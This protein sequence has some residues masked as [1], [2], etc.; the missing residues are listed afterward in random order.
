[1][2]HITPATAQ[3]HH[4]RNFLAGIALALP[5]SLLLAGL[6]KLVL[7]ASGL[8]NEN[9][10]W[11]ELALFAALLFLPCLW[12]GMQ[13][14]PRLIARYDGEALQAEP[15]PTVGHYA[16]GAQ[17]AIQPPVWTAL[18]AWCRYGTGTG[19][20]PF[21]R[22]SIPPEMA[23]PFSLAVMSGDDAAGKAR[24]AHAFARHLDRNDELAALSATS[25]W[26]GVLLKLAV[27]WHELWWWR[28]RHPRQPWDCGYLADD[29][30]AIAR[31]AAFRPRR[32]TLI[33]ATRLGSSA[34]LEQVLQI[35][36]ATQ[37]DYHH[38]VRLLVLELA[39][40]GALTRLK[41]QTK[42]AA[43]DP[44]SSQQPDLIRSVDL[45]IISA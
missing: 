9:A 4:F 40:P 12:A 31:L 10:F 32:P 3:P 14:G 22:P 44:V 42:P 13:I 23:L 16:A 28:Q 35:F 33:I 30:A 29:A 45:T 11:H 1:M 21:H 6:A 27:K 20:Q 5:S 8:G 38:P 19:R 7:L 25:R 37:A 39:V 2:T 18:E 43:P 26:R 34:H 17:Q 41:N 24:L 15:P 36:C